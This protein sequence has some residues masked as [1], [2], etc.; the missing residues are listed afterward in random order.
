ML[1]SIPSL[2]VILFAAS[3]AAQAPR[4]GPSDANAKWYQDG[5][6]FN[7]NFGTRA[8][9]KVSDTINQAPA[10][11]L[12][13]AFGYNFNQWDLLGRVDYY[14]HFM[15]PG[16]KGNNE[17]IAH[18]VALSLLGNFKLIPLFGGDPAAPWQVDA[19]IGS[20]LT[21]SWNRDMM[22]FVESNS[23]FTDW[24]D[25]FLPGKDDMGHILLGVTPK[26]YF[27]SRVALTLDISTFM[28]FSQDFTY[29]YTERITGEGLG[30]IMTYSLGITIR[31]K[32]YK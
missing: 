6:I 24:Q 11:A 20:G 14:N 3:L 30:G 15:I 27:N 1:K 8:F 22:N 28:L 19:Y 21:T 9:G 32:F 31:P 12:S 17:S 16:Y 13:G 5:W 2:I 23:N 7:A 25:P 18:S 4:L 26:Y 10:L 29:D